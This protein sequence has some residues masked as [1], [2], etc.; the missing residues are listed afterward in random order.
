M[1]EWGT[2]AELPATDEVARTHLA[3]PMAP[4]LS[5]RMVDQVVSAVRTFAA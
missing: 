1:R 2:G 4:N 3:I 5:S